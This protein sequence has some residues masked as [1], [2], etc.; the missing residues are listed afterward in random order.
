MKIEYGRRY[1]PAEA[2]DNYC[3]WIM[4]QEYVSEERGKFLYCGPGS[5]EWYM[6]FYALR[7]LSLGGT[8]LNKPEY[9]EFAEPYL[10]TYC[11]EQLP[12]GALSSNYRRK[13][14]DEMDAAELEHLIR[15]G[16][17]NL[18]DNGS[19]CQAV[20]QAAMLTHDPARKAAYLAT[21]KKWLDC[22]VPIWALPD[23][24]YGNGIWVGHKL[25][26]TYSCAINVCSALSCYGIISGEER[27]VKNAEGFVSF[28][29][30]HTLPD[31]RPIFFDL[32]PEP[33]TSI[34]EDY[35][36][37]FYMLEGVCWTH[38]AS[39]DPEFRKKV[40]NFLKKWI[41]GEY[42]ILKCWPERFNWFDSM[43][44]SFY[45]AFDANGDPMGHYNGLGHYW[46]LAKSNAIP[47]LF[48]YYLKYI[49]ENAELRDR[50]EKGVRYLC[51][52]LNAMQ[53]GVM[54]NPR[55][56][57]GRMAVQATGF[58]GLSI[59]EAIRPGFVFE[60]MKGKR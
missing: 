16:K 58:A 40:E 24:S 52:P 50:M 8:L 46:K 39:K 9:T 30:D 48:S 35:G 55:E 41:F 45:N 23:G 32:Y 14:A 1:E 15:C 7:T 21:V 19:N 44:Y 20:L 26:G 54:A 3:S 34:L 43:F 27:Y 29:C 5:F 25:N 49:E 22:W 38:F 10:D 28:V 60:L 11:G 18:A 42:G 51:L 2:L 47:H 31:G 4:E 12:N 53:N 33:H 13:R 59:A 36:H 17:L 37:I 6:V 56:Q 57:Y